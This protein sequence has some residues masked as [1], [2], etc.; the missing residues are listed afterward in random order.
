[1]GKEDVVCIHI[2]ILL[3]HKKDESESSAVKPESD[4]QSEV[5]QKE[6]SKHHIWIHICGI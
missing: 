2:G 4:I 3:S 1:M 6:N 5:S